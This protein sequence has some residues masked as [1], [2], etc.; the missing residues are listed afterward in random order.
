VI[1]HHHADDSQVKYFERSAWCRVLPLRWLYR[2]LIEHGVW[3]VKLDG[4]EDQLLLQ[5]AKHVPFSYRWFGRTLTVAEIDAAHREWSA[6]NTIKQ[7]LQPE[8][9]ICPFLINPWTLA[10][11]A[12]Y[13][14]MRK[15]K[16]IAVLLAIC[17]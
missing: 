8:D 3:Y 10:M 5:A 4:T 15:G 13:V 11:R 6:W 9:R 7:Q 2:N 14:V 12:G 16:A 17:S 1:H